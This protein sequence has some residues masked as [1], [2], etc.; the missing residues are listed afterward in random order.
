MCVFLL[1]YGNLGFGLEMVKKGLCM[2]GILMEIKGIF[3]GRI[4]FWLV[5]IININGSILYI[6]IYIWIIWWTYILSKS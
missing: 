2:G 4:I 5:L 6:K 3:I 1:I